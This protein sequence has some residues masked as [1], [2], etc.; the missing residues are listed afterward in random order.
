MTLRLVL[1][2]V[3]AGFGIP[4][5]SEKSVERLI[6]SDPATMTSSLESKQLAQIADAAATSVASGGASAVSVP[7]LAPYLDRVDDVAP[8]APVAEAAANKVETAAVL[9]PPADVPPAP[10]AAASP[11]PRVIEKDFSNPD[12]AFEIAFD[13]V[14][15]DFAA[16]PAG[17]LSPAP[18]AVEEAVVA[19]EPEPTPSDAIVTELNAWAQGLN[20]MPIAVEASEPVAE[21]EPAGC[22]MDDEEPLV[23]PVD[24]DRLG[25]A[26]RL[27]HEA[28]QAWAR[29]FDGGGA[30]RT[31]RD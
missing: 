27:T 30:G 28:V 31:R 7:I 17:D 24:N 5:T 26:I 9:P 16:S 12:R 2:G 13:A 6:W 21:Q 4:L 18:E 1:M 20:L 8:T 14:L 29:L 10:C 22:F 15:R 11:T 23:D 19:T 25:T 3:V